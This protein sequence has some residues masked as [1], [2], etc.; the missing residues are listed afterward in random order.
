MKIQYV[1]KLSYDIKQIVKKTPNYL[2]IKTGNDDKIIF[3]FKAN[4]YFLN[5]FLNLQ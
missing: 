1:I 2:S 4:K 3:Q 5:S